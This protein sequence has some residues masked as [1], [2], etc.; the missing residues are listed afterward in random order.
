MSGDRGRAREDE[1]AEVA[2]WVIQQRLAGLSGTARLTALCIALEDT[3][4]E[5]RANVP[6]FVT[7]EHARLIGDMLLERVAY[8]VGGTESGD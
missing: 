8:R 7:I 4:I 2:A 5:T 3:L 6:A 1:A